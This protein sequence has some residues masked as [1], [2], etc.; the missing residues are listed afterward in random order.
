MSPTVS[1]VIVTYNKADTLPDA[2]NS[3]LGQ[4]YPDFEVLVVDD[5]STDATAERVKAYGDKIRYLPKKNGGT[6]SARNLGI[7][8]ARGPFVAFLDGDDP[9]RT[10]ASG[11]IPPVP[12]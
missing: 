1:V 8:E 5:G 3:V 11:F 12:E 7:A 9:K 4:T 6:G 2:I 10:G